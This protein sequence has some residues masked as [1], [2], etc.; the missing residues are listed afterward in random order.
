MKAAVISLTLTLVAAGGCHSPMSGTWRL[1]P[2]Q[3]AHEATVASITLADDGTFSAYAKNGSRE[4]ALIGYYH[5]ANDELTLDA[6][7]KIHTYGAKLDGEELVLTQ[8][9][10]ETRMWR[11]KP[12]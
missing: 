9:K 2:G 10:A 3:T 1:A 4:E 7:G 6:D 8:E 11:L 5:V 12:R